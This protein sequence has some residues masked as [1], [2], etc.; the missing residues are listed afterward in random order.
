MMDVLKQ[1][2]RHSVAV[3]SLAVAVSGLSYNTWRNEQTEEN[4]NVRAAGFELLVKLGELDRIIF[5]GHYARD[6]Q[7]GNPKSGWAYV[8]T[9]RDLGRL[10]PEPAHSSSEELYRQWQE[11]SEALGVGSDSPAKAISDAI[12]NCR[13]DV[14]TVLAALD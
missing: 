3:I 2:R 14:L 6:L 12:D 13:E 5:F 7:M 9:I 8:L 4:R 11:K 10:M 1:L